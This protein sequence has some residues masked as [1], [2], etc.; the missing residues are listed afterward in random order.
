M[1]RSF[2]VPCLLLAVLCGLPCRATDPDPEPR[3][4]SPICVIKTNHGT[5]KVELYPDKAPVTVKNFLGYV[6]K[7]HYDDTVFHRVIDN[8]MI[9][10]GGYKKGVAAAQTDAAVHALLKQTGKPIPCESANGLSNK[11][12]TLAV[13]RAAAANSAT[14]QFFIN[15]KD[16]DFLDQGRAADKVGYCVFGK[17]VAGMEVVEKIRKARTKRLNTFSDV[18]TIDVVIESIRRVSR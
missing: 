7:K 12:G 9:Q 8:F 16:N 1:P 4:K 3:S 5:I 10:G 18:P 17:V 11:R 2:L 15:V 13:A 14:S 6:R